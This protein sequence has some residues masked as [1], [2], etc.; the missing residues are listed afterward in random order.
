MALE[1][2][3]IVNESA[4]IRSVNGYVEWKGLNQSFSSFEYLDGEMRNMTGTITLSNE[5]KY[6]S[7]TNLTVPAIIAGSANLVKEGSGTLTLSG[8]NSYYGETTVSGGT[9][10]VPRSASLATPRV[11]VESGATFQTAASLNAAVEINGGTLTLGDMDQPSVLYFNSLSLDNGTINFNLY[12]SNNYNSSFDNLS[13]SS[14]NL[15]S[16][17][18]NLRF[19]DSNATDWWNA[20]NDYAANGLTLISGNIENYNNVNNNFVVNVN[21]APTTDWRLTADSSGVYLFANGSGPAPTGEIWYFANTNDIYEGSWTIDGTNKLGAKFI[22][23]DSSATYTGGVYM[24]SNGK[25]EIGAG[26]NLTIEGEISGSGAVTKTGDGTLTL[27]NVNTYSGGTTVSGG[28]LVVENIDAIGTGDLTIDNAT[29]SS[30]EGTLPANSVTITGDSTFISSNGWNLLNNFSGSGTLTLIGYGDGRFTIREEHEATNYTGTFIVGTPDQAG[31]LTL[32]YANVLNSASNIRSVNG[33]IDWR[34]VNQSFNSFEYLDGEMVA[35]TGTL[36]LGNEFKYN[37]STD[38]TVP[39]II[40]GDANLVKEGSGT[41]TL[42]TAN[43][44][45]GTTTI[46]EG[47]LMAE[48]ASAVGKGGLYVNNATL[49][50]VQGTLQSS[51]VTITG[52]STFISTTGWNLFKNFSGSGTLT[53]TGPGYLAF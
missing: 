2:A 28:T 12:D 36:T 11:T 15:S 44:Y 46:S 31:S 39:A 6:N 43:T 10:I 27:T 1:S 18:I 13:V 5:F 47:A 33:K 52:D 53:L 32:R 16:G 42:S 19:L 45:S 38:L 40:A 30:V 14:A 7:S 51:S 49:G 23:G 48:N 9:L 41:L 17:V 21:G 3:N 4:N 20:I 29:I 25:F 22:E 26:H 34:D 50:S 24:N 8:A 37:S 35:M